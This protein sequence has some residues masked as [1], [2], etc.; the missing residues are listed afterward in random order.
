[1]RV[2]DPGRGLRAGA[3]DR[4]RDALAPR[5]PV[6]PVARASRDRPRPH[7]IGDRFRAVALERPA[8]RPR[9]AGARGGSPARAF[10]APSS[11]PNGSAAS[12][13]TTRRRLHGSEPARWPP[14]RRPWSAKAMF[15]NALVSDDAA[16]SIIK[17]RAE[18]SRAEPS[19]AEPSRAEPSR[20]EPSRAEPSRAEPSR[21]EPSRAEPSRAEPSRAEPSRAEPSRAEPSRAEPSRAEPSRAEPSRASDIVQV[22]SRRLTPFPSRPAG[23]VRAPSERPGRHRAGVEASQGR[24]RELRARSLTACLATPAAT[25]RLGCAP[26]RGSATSTHRTME[27]RPPSPAPTSRNPSRPGRTRTATSSPS[28][29]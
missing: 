25:L 20:A 10:F 5:E 27:T 21:A 24:R 14:S 12:V 16:K 2:H 29:R 22:Q 17:R 18:P 19:R 23:R 13:E 15:L 7:P 4:A 6:E 11:C 9:V 3:A 26:T 8:V 28:S 1:M